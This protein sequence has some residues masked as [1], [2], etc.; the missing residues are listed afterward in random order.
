MPPKG[1]V[2]RA[3]A[4]A[5]RRDFGVTTA[6]TPTAEEEEA[7]G[8]PAQLQQ[9]Q[10]RREALESHLE[11]LDLRVYDLETVYLRQYVELGGCLFDGF[12]L[13]RQQQWGGVTAAAARAVRRPP[14]VRGCTPFRRVIVCSRHPRW[15]RWVRW[16]AS[17]Q[18]RRQARGR[19]AEDASA[20]ALTFDSL[21]TILKWCPYAFLFCFFLFLL[22]GCFPL[23]FFFFF[24][25]FVLTLTRH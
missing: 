2:R 20:H 23:L 22:S 13:E 9:L 3:V 8:L 4:A 11:T 19:G 5:A 10:K 1:Y 17:R 18:W 16:S 15:G 24:F 6:F 14:T 7:I 12:G 21:A 25:F